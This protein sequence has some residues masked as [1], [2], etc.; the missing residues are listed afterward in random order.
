MIKHYFCRKSPLLKKIILIIFVLLIL[1]GSQTI[2]AQSQSVLWYTHPAEYFEEAFLLGNGTLGATI[3]G[4]VNQEKILL[5]EATLWSGEPVDSS[6]LNPDAYKYIPLIREALAN[7]DYKKADSLNHFVQG[8]YSESY[9][10][11]GTV[12]IDFN[13]AENVAAYKRQLDLNTAVS[14]TF[15][16]SDNVD[17]TREYFVSYPQKVLVIRLKASEKRTLNFTVHFESLL[18]YSTSVSDSMLQISGYAPY[19]AEPSYRGDIA[20][21]VLFD[22]SRGTRF[23]SYV[24]VIINDGEKIFTDSS[25]HVQN[26]S[27]ALILIS[28]TTSFNGF[29][30]N[31]AKGAEQCISAAKDFNRQ[32][33]SKTYNDLKSAH[34]N[35]YQ[36]FYNRVNL[37]LGTTTAP[38][39]PTNERLKRYSEGNEDKNLEILY[40]NFGRYLMISGSRTDGVPMNLQGI[41][42]PYLRPPWSSNFTLNINTQENY[43]LAEPGNL[44]EMH[45]PLLYFISKLATT[46]SVTAKQFYGCEGWTACH[47]S[48]IWAMSHPVGDFGEGN[49]N[50]ANWNMSGPWLCTHLWEHYLFTRD[51][52]FLQNKAWPL[53]KGS[54]MFCMDWLI[55]DKDG[56]LI[57]SPS[58]SPENLYV[59]TDGYVGATMYGGTSDLAIIRELL[60][61]TLRAAEVL[62]TDKEFQKKIR[63]TLNKLLPYKTGSQGQLQEWYCDWADADPKHRH[64]S[65]LYGLYPG[66]HITPESTPALAA[67]CR[68]TLEIKGDETTGWSMGW[69]I[70]LWARLGDG[71]H[72]Y[73]LYRRLLKYVEPDQKPGGFHGG[74]TYPNLLD[75]H[76]PF[77]IDGNCGGAAGMIEMLVQSDENT[78]Y[79]LPAIPD[80]WENGSV[81][82]LRTRAGVDII[83]LRWDKFANKT[84][85]KVYMRSDI[86]KKTTVVYN[87]KKTVVR[88]K[89]NKVS[90]IHF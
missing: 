58:T 16:I 90:E 10:P 36:R 59:T 9:A 41:W 44:S 72:A 70:N 76:P 33:A 53:M 68:K 60:Q 57:T 80:E 49:P 64:Q 86:N 46:G 2:V 63:Q 39:L 87:G 34:I 73:T 81:S 20:D 66:H 89:K 61:Q 4:G 84:L 37:N 78:V 6:D 85:V 71:N 21:A 29:N 31:P 54:A 50:W 14:K 23:A 47:N 32:A 75:A 82:G 17:F 55:E 79:I 88:L 67:A 62:N 24:S 77:Q 12:L 18:K 25:I 52:D 1:S 74:G 69:R 56:H 7:E 8:A 35:D 40:F 48:D 51:M 26:A 65:H 15:F 43:W 45:E 22:E 30:Q 38:D 5:N 83:H 27:E 42:N 11:A 3:Y 13:H 19:H 28:L